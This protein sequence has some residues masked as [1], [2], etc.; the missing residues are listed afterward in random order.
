MNGVALARAARVLRPDIPILLTTGYSGQMSEGLDAF[1][2]SLPLLRKPYRRAELAQKIGE[3]LAAPVCRTPA[4]LKVL[5]VEDDPLVRWA[6]EAMFAELGHAVTSAGTGREALRSLEAERFDVLFTDLGLPD[7]GGAELAREATRRAG[8]MRVIVA[9]GHLDPEAGRG[10][11]HG[12]FHLPSP[13]TAP[14]FSASWAPFWSVER[15][16]TVPVRAIRRGR[17]PARRERS[18]C[19][20]LPGRR[21]RD[22]HA[23]SPR[24]RSG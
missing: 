18:R 22:R 11:P 23:S 2:D 21:R 9:T 20:R 15:P 13:T 16:T 7:I 10:C 3:A 24:R 14:I 1:K 4:S 17:A 19:R 5:L 6:T 12:W 8:H